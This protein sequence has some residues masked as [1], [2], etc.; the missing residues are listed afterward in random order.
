MLDDPRN[1]GRKMVI[2]KVSVTVSMGLVSFGE[3][4]SG[5]TALDYF[6]RMKADADAQTKKAKEAGRNQVFC[7]GKKI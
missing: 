1:R 4:N 5:E 2:R 7:R 3:R 6:R